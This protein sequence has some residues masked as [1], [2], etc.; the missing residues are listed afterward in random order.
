MLGPRSGSLDAER[1]RIS[2]ELQK[3]PLA[4]NTVALHPAILKRYE[5]QLFRLESAL[6]KGVSAGDSEATEAIQDLVETTV[7]V[8]RDPASPGGVAVEIAGPLN[9][10]IGEEAC[11]NR[12]KGVWV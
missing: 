6:G 3:E 2:E 10:P 12:V 7:T 5:Q 1:E 11:P 4:P 9:A 8:F